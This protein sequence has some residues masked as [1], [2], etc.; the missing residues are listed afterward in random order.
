MESVEMRVCKGVS[1][2]EGTAVEGECWRA[3]V[4]ISSRCGGN[5][6]G[7]LEGSVS[8]FW[9]WWGLGGDTGV[10]W[11]YGDVCGLVPPISWVGCLVQV[12]RDE[13]VEVVGG[14]KGYFLVLGSN[15]FCFGEGIDPGG[16]V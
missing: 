3:L 6:V 13:S 4:R 10:G 7:M 2:M 8:G 1:I 15:L 9:W 11:S 16:K 14:F 12:C 5:R